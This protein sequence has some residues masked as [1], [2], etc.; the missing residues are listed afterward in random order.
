SFESISSHFTVFSLRIS[1]PP[2]VSALTLHDALPILVKVAAQ[3]QVGAALPF[4][5]LAADA[6]QGRAQAFL[7]NRVIEG[8]LQRIDH[9][10]ALRSEEH[11]SELQSRFDFV[12][13][14]LLEK[15]NK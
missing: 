15:N 14:H 3:R 1:S 7:Q 11:T 4:R 6:V 13:R 2:D 8:Q 10:Y 5:Q 9:M 12:C